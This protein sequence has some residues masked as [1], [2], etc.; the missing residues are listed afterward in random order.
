MVS[1]RRELRCC[2]SDDRAMIARKG[3]RAVREDDTLSA[4]NVS[5]CM[6]SHLRICASGLF[7]KMPTLEPHSLLGSALQLE[8]V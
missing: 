6:D 5:S 7:L 1:R 4:L 8:A 2:A 3:R